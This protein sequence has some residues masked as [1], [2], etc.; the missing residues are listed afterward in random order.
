MDGEECWA[1]ETS[2]DGERS[3]WRKG[4][5]E[6]LWPVMNTSGYRCCC[7]AVKR[8]GSFASN[9]KTAVFDGPTRSSFE[10]SER[11]RRP[12]REARS[13]RPRIDPR[14]EP[15]RPDPQAFVQAIRSTVISATGSS[16]SQP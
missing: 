11:S 6:E 5:A 3:R 1:V 2:K 13:G 4:S 8:A 14:A 12:R 7:V 9:T 15:D 10:G 16:T